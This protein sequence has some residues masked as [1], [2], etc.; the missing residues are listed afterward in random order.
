[1][2]SL[3]RVLL[4][5]HLGV[6]PEIRYT[7]R[8]STPVC[9]FRIATSERF[10]GSDGQ[11][12]EATEWHRIVVWGK[13]A[14]PCAE[15]LRKGSAVLVEGSL[16]TREWEESSGAK[17]YTTEIKASRVLFLTPRDREAQGGGYGGAR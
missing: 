16:T 8:D 13:Q 7:A 3:N 1:M 4:M 5:G 15:H 10:K 11:W 14:Q 9:N 2:A 12:Q 6:D 17:R